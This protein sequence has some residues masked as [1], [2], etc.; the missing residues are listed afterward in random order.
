MGDSLTSKLQTGITGW[1][2]V[3]ITIVIGSVV[4]LKFK[5]VSGVTAAL[6]ATIDAFVTAFQFFLFLNK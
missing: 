4:L 2:M 5:G 1:V 3:A 6:N